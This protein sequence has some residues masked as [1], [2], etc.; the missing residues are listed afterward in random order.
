MKRTPLYERHL[1]LDARM[2][3]FAGW[4]MP[5]Q[6]PTGIVQEHLSVRKQAGLFDVSHMGRFGVSG[7]ESLP[8]LQHVLSN[9][10]AA[11]QPET[12]QYT[13]IPNERGGAVDDAYLYRVGAAEEKGDRKG[14]EYLL[15]V[16]AANREKDWE[17]L[18]SL[19]RSFGEVRL[20]DRT[21][22][23]AMLSLQGPQS[24]RILASLFGQSA[25]PA[26]G[27]NHLSM[28]SFEQ[29]ELAVARTGYAGEPLG[30]ELFLPRRSV[31]KLWNQ[32]LEAGAAPIGLGARDTLRLEAG[33]PL[34]GHELGKGPENEEIPIFACPLARFAVSFSPSKGRFVGRPCLEEQLDAYR[35]I[36]KASHEHR[37][38]RQEALPL[39]IR[40]FQVLDEG[41][42]RRG[43]EVFA[44][45][46]RVGWVTSGTMV[47]YWVF[48]GEGACSVI[49]DRSQHRA[50]GMALADSSIEEQSQVEIEVRGRR[51]KA[52][53][54]SRLLR[55]G[56]PP[57]ARP[58]VW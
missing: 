14:R 56:A 3:E 40:L 22:E 42:A 18:Q 4:E 17:H 48:E 20:R 12:A 50:I 27:R 49:T 46:R 39:V 8:F 41:I 51:L 31:E 21:D 26:P 24:P 15:V 10:A 23:L 57:Y 38:A 53:I 11:L 9:D 32:I 13:M 29:T 45:G 6:Y 16:N 28:S 36:V 35:G 30:F 37:S 43:S 44:R 25:L 5:V 55:S 34:Y 2:V 58:V 1:S 19:C 33:L 52:L 54:V 7:G 47:P